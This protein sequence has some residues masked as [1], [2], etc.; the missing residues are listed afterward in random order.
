M[1]E[2]EQQN[3]DEATPSGEDTEAHGYR[4]RGREES[5]RDANDN[6]E[7]EDTE[8]HAVKDRFRGDEA[9]EDDRDESDDKSEDRFSSSDSRLKRAVHSLGCSA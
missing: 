1:D 4:P 9:E 6:P 8:G 5:D 7:D 2:Q 3:P